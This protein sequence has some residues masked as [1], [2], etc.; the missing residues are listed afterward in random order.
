MNIAKHLAILLLVLQTATFSLAQEL[1]GPET[2]PCGSLASFEIVPPQEAVWELLPHEDSK[3][4]FRLD[5]SSKTLFFASP[6]EKEFTVLAAI[7]AEGKPVLFT[8]TF[9]NGKRDTN[10]QPPLEPDSTL[11]KWIE[12]QLPLSVKSPYVSQ[13]CAAVAAALKQITV[14]IDDGTIR[15]ARNAQAQVRISVTAALAKT[16]RT[17]VNAWMEFLTRLGEKIQ[18]EL[19][20]NAN[21]IHEIR[22]ILEQTVEAIRPDIE[23]KTIQTPSPTDCPKCRNAE[24]LQQLFRFRR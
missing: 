13:E 9:F 23:T 8:K 4:R 15:T 16:S 3:E 12:T 7:L 5:S 19:G 1:I 11:K 20:E 10:P 24:P 21:D 14:R 6:V 22:K 18:S 2:V 17:S